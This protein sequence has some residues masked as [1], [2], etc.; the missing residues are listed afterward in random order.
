MGVN[1]NI[2]TEPDVKGIDSVKGTVK[3]GTQDIA[4]EQW[5]GHKASKQKATVVL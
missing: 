4:C 5:S 3:L 1:R 2:K